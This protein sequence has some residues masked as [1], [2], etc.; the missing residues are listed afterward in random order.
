MG[1][2]QTLRAALLGA[3]CLPILPALAQEGGGVRMFLGLD[4]DFEVGENLALENP[5]ARQQQH[6][7]HAPV[8]RRGQRD[9]A[10]DA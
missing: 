3:L 1:Q 4:Q 2:K 8:L 5:A 10:P 6:L 7:D 9:R